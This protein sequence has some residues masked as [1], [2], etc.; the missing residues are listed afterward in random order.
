MID[1]GFFVKLFVLALL[2]CFLIHRHMQRLRVKW[3]RR[4]P[5]V[6]RVGHSI[7]IAPIRPRLN[8]VK[9]DFAAAAHSRGE[10]GRVRTGSVAMARARLAD[11]GFFHHSPSEEESERHAH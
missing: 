10:S 4:Q 6:E 8:A 2:V 7:D 3:A 11:F 9:Q 1:N 5:T